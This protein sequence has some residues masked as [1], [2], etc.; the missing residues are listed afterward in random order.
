M[1][2]EIGNHPFLKDGKREKGNK[3][4]EDG[5]TFPVRDTA[6]RGKKG[7]GEERRGGRE[8]GREAK[9]PVKVEK[10]FVGVGHLSVNGMRRDAQIRRVGP[11]F[12]SRVEDDRRE[13]TKG[14]ENRGGVV[15][16]EGCE[17][18]VQPEAIPPE[19]RDHVSIPLVRHLMQHC[20][21][22]VCREDT[23]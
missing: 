9:V 6:I 16:D 22:S 20:L 5:C 11:L 10:G 8:G 15:A 23:D 18:L 19:G 2:F 17:R 12:H 21:V 13:S 7:E 4:F 1:L 14:R 3:L